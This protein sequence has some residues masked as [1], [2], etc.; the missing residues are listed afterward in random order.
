LFLI[1]FMA[2]NVAFA[3]FMLCIMQMC[4][5]MYKMIPMFSFLML[6]AFI[7]YAIVVLKM[8]P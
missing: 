7:A 2:L 8:V 1:K 3:V 5:K 4:K 6:G